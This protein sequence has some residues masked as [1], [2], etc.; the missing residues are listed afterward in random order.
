M[1]SGSEGAGCQLILGDALRAAQTQRPGNGCRSLISD[2]RIYVWRTSEELILSRS[3]ARVY[4]ADGRLARVLVVIQT[5]RGDG[6][7][8]VDAPFRN[9]RC[10]GS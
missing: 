7:R 2:L 4:R 8:A 10:G 1:G 6:L 3:R 9:S 5:R